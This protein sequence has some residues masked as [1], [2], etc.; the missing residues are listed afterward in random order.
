M[1]RR[2]RRKHHR[3]RRRRKTHRKRYRKTRRKPHRKQRRKTRRRRRRRGGVIKEKVGLMDFLGQ[4]QTPQFK[5]AW[6]EKQADKNR[7][8]QMDDRSFSTSPTST[9]SSTPQ[10]LAEFYRRDYTPSSRLPP[11]SVGSLVT[12]VES[13]AH[14]PNPTPRP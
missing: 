13:A 4:Y 10:T 2:T 5:T 9:T 7:Q 6:R 8:A 1:S 12:P 11:S 3:K 14:P